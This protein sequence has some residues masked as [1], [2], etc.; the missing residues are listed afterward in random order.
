MI[1]FLQKARYYGS[2][3]GVG[4]NYAESL[5]DVKSLERARK[6]WLSLRDQLGNCTRSSQSQL[7][8]YSGV[9]GIHWIITM[10]SRNQQ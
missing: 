8:N 2:V 1:G 5:K 3:L 7:G 10:E 6:S 4:H 9:P